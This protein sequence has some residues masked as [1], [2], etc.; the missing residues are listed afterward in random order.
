MNELL[1][2][3]LVFASVIAIVG[4]LAM[5]LAARRKRLRDRLEELADQAGDGEEP[6]QTRGFRAIERIGAAVSLGHVSARLKQELIRAGYHGPSSATTYLGAKV[7]LLALGLTGPPVLLLWLN[8]PLPLSVLVTLS[9]AVG[10]FMLPNLFV[11]I[12]RRRRSKDVRNHLPDAVDLL[13]V[14]VSSGMGLDMAWNL[15]A[16]EVRG[17]STTLADEMALTNLEIHLGSPRVAA[18]RH[19]AERVGVDDIGSLVAVLVQSERFGTSIAD[20][21]RT[22]AGT[23]RETRSMRAEETAE[24]MAV[25][26]LFPMILFIFPAILVVLAGPAAIALSRALGK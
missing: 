26:L 15:V 11:S 19:L 6:A 14:C 2:S 8:A 12:R 3:I 22:F 23:M 4:A 18:M 16:D 13:E 1:I 17:V 21:L 24:K 10:L 7:L 25:R 20:A 5:S 9:V